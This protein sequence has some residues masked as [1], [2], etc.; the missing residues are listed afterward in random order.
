MIVQQASPVAGMTAASPSV[1]EEQTFEPVAFHVVGANVFVELVQYQQVSAG[2]IYLGDPQTRQS[3]A[4]VVGAG[5]HAIDDDGEEIEV[6]D[7]VIVRRGEL[8][9]LNLGDDRRELQHLK[10]PATIVGR[11]R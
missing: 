1:E 8:T 2:G 4:V 6:G 3:E 7:R 11:V 10:S 9:L 5:H